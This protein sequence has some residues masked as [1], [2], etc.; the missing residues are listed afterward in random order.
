MFYFL[1][2]FF[3]SLGLYG[4]Y[5][6]K[7]CIVLFLFLVCTIPTTRALEGAVYQYGFAFFEF[8][9]IGAIFSFLFSIVTV[10][11]YKKYFYIYFAL[12]F[13]VFY[14]AA[15]FFIFDGDY[16]YLVRDLRLLFIYLFFISFLF[17][18]GSIEV[19]RVS[20]DRIMVFSCVA[21]LLYY[22]FILSGGGSFNNEF[23]N[24]EN[25]YRYF[26]VTTYAAISYLLYTFTS[27]EKLS[28]L[29][30]LALFLSLILL[31]VS[32]YRVYIFAFI[33]SLIIVNIN[34]LKNFIKIT[35][36]SCILLSIAFYLVQSLDVQRLTDSLSIA[37]VYEQLY[38]RFYPAV[39]LINDFEIFNFVFG[40][41]FGT[42]FYIPWFEY[43]GLDVNH[44]MIDSTYMTM[45]VKQGITAF[46]YILLYVM[47]LTHNAVGKFKVSIMI[48]ILIVMFAF[49]VVYHEGVLI[50]LLFNYFL[51]KTKRLGNS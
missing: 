33:I 1:A 51:I 21:T 50:F 36:V 32:G 9:F 17:V 16:K 45:F 11:F 48:F 2:A 29:Q 10:G 8:F 34:M 13:T 28:S 20:I 30:K 4:C 40:L 3:F 22:L 31:L 47:L 44:N 35:L 5:K 39:V 19:S 42:V 38:T 46:I 6:P 37:G 43:Q 7:I 26:D 24:S 15:S 23:Y 14:I 25:R 18:Y 12:C 41:G 27:S 49:P